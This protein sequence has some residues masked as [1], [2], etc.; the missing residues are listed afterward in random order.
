[1]LLGAL[2]E[3]GHTFG[4]A[5]QLEGP[6]AAISSSLARLGLVYLSKFLDFGYCSTFICI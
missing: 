2:D 6:E 4:Y 3:D 5:G 1:M